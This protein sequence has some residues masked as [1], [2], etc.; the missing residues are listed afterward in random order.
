MLTFSGVDVEYSLVAGTGMR[1]SQLALGTAVFGLAP[2]PDGCDALVHA[3][4]DAGINTFDCANTYGNRPSFDRS[5]LPTA[6]QRPHAEELLGRALKGRRD[7]VV[8]CTKVSEPMGPGP[9]DGGLVIPGLGGHGGGLSRFHIMREVERSLRRLDT[10]HI[11]IYHFHHPDPDTAIDETLRAVDDLIHQG[12]VRYGGLSTFNGWQTAQAVLTAEKLGLSRPVLNQVPYSLVQRWPEAEVAPAAAA[13]GLSL[14]CFSPLAGGALAGRKAADRPYRGLK[15]WGLPFDYFP[16]QRQ[17]AE[18]L[19]QLAEQWGHAPAHLA[20]A[21]LLSRAPVAA[22][23]IGPE[24]PEELA[25]NLGVFELT[26]D[27]AQLA[28]IDAI[29]RP[30]P[31]LPL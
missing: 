11:D 12:K 19:E 2:T 28:E 18:S 14:T 21:W 10:D 31:V 24:T 15:R 13:L 8:L 27:D 20:L 7:E 9:N 29:G 5:G 22:A 23:I 4:L 6:D 17:A 26:L 30:D 25:Q 3:A 1:V 16:A